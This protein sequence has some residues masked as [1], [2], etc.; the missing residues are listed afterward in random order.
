MVYYWFNHMIPISSICFWGSLTHDPMEVASATPVQRSQQVLPESESLKTHHDTVALSKQ[1]QQW[2]V[3]SFWRFRKLTV[4]Y[5]HTNKSCWGFFSQ[6]P[7]L[8]LH[9]QLS[10]W[11]VLYIYTLYTR[12]CY[13]GRSKYPLLSVNIIHVCTCILLVQPPGLPIRYTP[14]KCI[15]ACS[16]FQNHG[17]CLNSLKIAIVLRISKFCQLCS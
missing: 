11:C 2:K 8:F 1:T 5:L 10:N 7:R 6:S 16:P 9:M 4:K 12:S 13:V 14:S 15:A 17:W 3:L